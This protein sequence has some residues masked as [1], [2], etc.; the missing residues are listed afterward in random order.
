[1]Q[2]LLWDLFQACSEFLHTAYRRRRI[3]VPLRQATRPSGRASL[4]SFSTIRAT[5]FSP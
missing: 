3:R 2:E 5:A 1:M 4:Y